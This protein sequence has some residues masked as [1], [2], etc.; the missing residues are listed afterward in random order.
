MNGLLF[1]GSVVLAFLLASLASAQD[2]PKDP[3]A[4]SDEPPRLQETVDVEAELPALPPL[5][6]AATRI[7]A[8][9]KDLPFTLSVIPASLLRDQDGF[10]LND[11]LKNAS[12][13]N[14]ST[15]FG[16]FDYF[17][18]RGLDSLT[19]S[20][21]L[22]DGVSEPES[23]FYPLYNVRQIEVLKGPASFLYG[24]NPLAGAVQMVRKQPVGSRFGE[25]SFT[26]GRYGTYAGTID[27]NVATTDG[28]VAFRLN[29]T[30]QGTDNYRDLPSGKTGA[31]NP[32]LLWRPDQK[33]RLLFSYEYVRNEWPPDTGIPFVGAPRGG[34]APVARTQSY[35]SSF[36]ASTQNVTRVRFDAE[37]QLSDSITLRNRFYFTQLEWNSD[38]TLILGTFEYPGA[39]TYVAR[40]LTLLDDT[41]KLL[42]DQLE[43][44]ATF[45]TGSVGHNLLLGVELSRRQDQFTQDVA[46]LDPVSLLNPVEQAGSVPPP[47]IPAYGQAGDS[48]ARVIAPYVVDRLAF[49]KRWQAFVGARLDVLD[50]ED[51]PSGTN[52]SDTK[53][54]PLLGLVF[55]PTPSL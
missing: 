6:G 28:K 50:Y 7:P 44:S 45:Q 27:G 37:R 30:L 47:T 31:V 15:G 22:T 21:V 49:A 24:A 48:R 53:L 41:Q 2:K 17:T 40:T 9:A 34:L 43:L 25:A 5:S 18:V 12:G 35:Q 38:G 11:A 3:K 4:A 20:L 52:R 39:G 32:T 14:V 16:I 46:L 55:A 26:Y 54:S 29:G 19:G 36:D 51:K 33:T 10:M 13:V 1:R 8:P 23:T 42:G